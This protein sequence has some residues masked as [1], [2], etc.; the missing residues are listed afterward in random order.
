MPRWMAGRGRGWITAEYG[1]LPASTGE[2]KRRDVSQGAAGRP[3][4]RDPAPDRPLAAR[5]DR[6]RGA[7][8][9]HG[10]DRL[11][12]AG[13]RRRHALRGDHGRLRG[14]ASWR[15]DR[16]VAEGKLEPVP[17]TARPSP[18]CRA[19][20]WT[21]ARCS[22]S[23]T[24]RTPRAEVD[25]NVVMTGDGGL[26]EVQATAERT[27][28]SRDLAG[29]A[30]CARRGGHRAAARGPVAAA[31]A[32]AALGA[33]ARPCGW[34]SPPV[35]R[36]SCGSWRACSRASSSSRCRTRWSCRRRRATTFAAN[37]L[38]KARAA[39]TA[40]GLPAV[41]DD[42]GIAAAAL[43][44]APGVRSARYAGE[45]RDGRGEPRQAAAR[46]P[47]RTTAA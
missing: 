43:G 3:H 33:G 17:L 36:T 14:A 11:R 8:R 15:C 32:A 6:L 26:V 1:M 20:W 18:P 2:R 23:T 25:T 28:L 5:R 47:G 24:R 22:T 41:A 39:A 4:R 30:A 46:G 10:L 45:R 7:R 13:G 37:A 27:P 40:T 29:R 12:R 19:A 44:G 38:V 21:A 16:L 35:T 31:V 34:C 9:A 42:S